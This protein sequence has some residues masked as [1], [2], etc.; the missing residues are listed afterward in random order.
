MRKRIVIVALALGLWVSSIAVGAMTVPFPAGRA[1]SYAWSRNP[2]GDLHSRW[3]DEVTDIIEAMGLEGG[4]SITFGNGLTID[5]DTN[6]TLTI[7]DADS[8]EDLIF[9][10]T[11]NTLTLT[12]ATGMVLWD[13]TVVVPKADQFLFDP[14]ADP[15]G[16]VEGTVY[17]DSDDDNLYVRTSAGLVDLTASAA[18]GTL[19]AA[20]DS[21]GSGAGKKIE[22]DAG[23]VEIEVDDNKIASTYALLLDYDDVTNNA[24][25]LSITNAG[26]GN[27]IDIEGTSG[28]DIE[29]TGDT[30]SITTA[31]A[32]T[33]ASAD[34][35]GAAGITLGNDATI[36]N[37]V[38]GEIQFMDGAEDV[39]F[40]FAT[41]NTLSLTSDSDVATIAFGDLDAF[42]GVNSIAMDAAASNITLT[43]TGTAQDLTIALAG[44]TPNASLFLTSTG[45]AAD[46]IR[47]NA[48][49]GAFDIDA[50]DGIAIDIAG[51]PGEDFVLT[52]TGGSITLE[53]TEGVEDAIVIHAS[54]AVGGIDIT[55]NADIDITTAGASGEDI[56]I[57]N[58][59][60]SVNIRGNENNAG[61]VVIDT[62]GAGGSSEAITILND[63]GTSTTVTAAAVQISA[64]VG[65]VELWSGLNSADAINLYADGSTS[66][67]IV[68]ENVTGTGAASV[69][70]KST[71]GGI[72]MVV[73][74]AKAVTMTATAGSNS[75]IGNST[76]DVAVAGDN[77]D[78][79]VT[80]ATDDVFQILSSASSQVFLDIDLGT[81]DSIAWG[82]N[83]NA[84]ATTV[85]GATFSA[86]GGIGGTSGA[87]GATTIQGGTGG[88]AI[89]A[90]SA[91]G[92]GGQMNISGGI[93]GAAL[94]DNNGAAGGAFV[95]VGGIG[96][97]AR[98]TGNAG[99]G[100]NAS[101]TAGAG[102]VGV[103]GGGDPGA[104]GTVAITAGAGGGGT[105]ADNGAAGG[106]AALVGGA[107]GIGAAAKVGGA[108]G[109]TSIAGGIGGASLTGVA[110]AGGA[111]NLTGGATGSGA[112]GTAGN[113]GVVNIDGGVGVTGGS[114]TIDAGAGTTTDGSITI[115]STTALNV[116]ITASGVITYTGAFYADSRVIENHSANHTLTSPVDIGTLITVDT[117]AV[118][119]TLPAVEVG[120]TYTIMNLGAD[121]TEIHV[122]MNAVDKVLGGCGF[123]AALNDGDKLTNTGATADKGDF[124][125]LTYGSD[126]GWFITAMNGIWAD[127]G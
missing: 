74:T 102:V 53:A 67:G 59:G 21:G 68:I 72:T 121:G 113:G 73:P 126:D 20:Y 119:I 60:G 35:T 82:D 122:D 43:A 47:M 54:T 26:I 112:T 63:Q 44:T 13:F 58:T 79:T 93:G 32:V 76:G 110:G 33:A 18:S 115:G 31:G 55:S 15:I 6:A 106:T 80:A 46:A 40:G 99:G 88:I 77:I 65:S 2:S 108:G 114:V 9:T 120:A 29:G 94:T 103:V 52:N 107:G 118:V 27:S 83:S 105:T 69:H 70:L 56:S 96:G 28:N 92:A 62:A 1:N 127:G 61:A 64:T 78:F 100:G 12:S 81:T 66:S 48:S 125:T 16:S 41:N 25:V 116:G 19:D 109:A 17:Y 91:A 71:A 11:S 101:V 75:A 97:V 98:G 7:T 50:A 90:T 23:G 86:T 14:V 3:A 42:T 85:V 123:A 95:S 38:D 49:D 37:D 51:A 4:D 36:L 57:I 30:W 117:A 87:G 89:A 34:F 5:N 104:A 22:A 45:T 124:V 10:F 39:S 84:G 24:L 8:N 111:L